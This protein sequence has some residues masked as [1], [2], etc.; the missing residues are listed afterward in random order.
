MKLNKIMVINMLVTLGFLSACNSGSSKTNPLSSN[1]LTPSA[2]KPQNSLVIKNGE[3]VSTPK[4]NALVPFIMVKIGDDGYRS[5]TG[6]FLAP[7]KVLTAAHCVVKLYDKSYGQ[8]LESKDLIPTKAISIIFPKNLN[9]PMDI[10]KNNAGRLIN[11]PVKAVYVKSDAFTGVNISN[12]SFSV[13]DY[14]KINDLAI[15]ELSKAPKYKFQMEIASVAP[16]VSAEQ[17]VVGFGY[18]N[19]DN[20]KVKDQ[21]SGNAGLIRFG[22]T[23]VSNSSRAHHSSILRIGG[24]ISNNTPEVVACKGDSGGPSLSYN[25]SNL[26]YTVTGIVSLGY[27][28]SECSFEPSIYMSVAYYKNWIESGYLTD[29]LKIGKFLKQ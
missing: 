4:L 10:N 15:I 18:N 26:S 6:V 5:C 3:P 7:N 28:A 12:N 24:A 27:G 23:I 25:E 8:Y 29:S 16:K 20:A 22:K 13:Y 9:K 2:T 19:G 11:Y 17:I 21:S 14:A 1:S